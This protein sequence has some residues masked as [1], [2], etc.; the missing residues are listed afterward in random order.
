MKQI[1][2]NKHNLDSFKHNMLLKLPCS[3]SPVYTYI[4]GLFSR[5]T[6]NLELS[7]VNKLHLQVQDMKNYF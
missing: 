6:V 5:L 7:F 1:D 3:I 2:F 4:L